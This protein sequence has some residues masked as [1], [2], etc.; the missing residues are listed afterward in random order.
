MIMKVRILIYVSLLFIG[1]AL[2]LYYT[3]PPW[4]PWYCSQHSGFRS[5]A[6]GG[7][8]QRCEQARCVVQKTEEIHVPG[9][10]DAD[11]YRFRCIRK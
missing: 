8:D 11:G 6:W 3:N 2:V 9:A 4:T 5:Y 10:Y 1:T 7:L